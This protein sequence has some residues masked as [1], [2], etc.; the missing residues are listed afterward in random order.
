M[1]RK[2]CLFLALLF[3][4]VLVF[5][6]LRAIS[7]KR[8]QKASISEEVKLPVLIDDMTLYTENL[9]SNKITVRT[10]NTSPARLPWWLRW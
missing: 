2:E 3:N 4:I 10:K 7:K 6:L 9:L 1:K 5:F 8:K